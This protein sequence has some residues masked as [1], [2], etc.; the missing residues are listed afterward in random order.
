MAKK[1]LIKVIDDSLWR[2]MKAISYLRDRK[3]EDIVEEAFREYIINHRKQYNAL[4]KA[5]VEDEGPEPNQ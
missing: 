3:I 2:Q 5:G 4:L 1:K